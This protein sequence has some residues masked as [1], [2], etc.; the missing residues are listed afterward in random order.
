MQVS[1]AAGTDNQG[2]ETAEFVG[3]LI[4]GFFGVLGGGGWVVLFLSNWQ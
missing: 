1:I 3:S 2:R 4:G